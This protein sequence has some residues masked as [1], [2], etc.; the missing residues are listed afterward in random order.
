MVCRAAMMREDGKTIEQ[1]AAWVKDTKKI[2]RQH[3]FVDDLQFLSR[4][5]RISG[6]A[7][8]GGAMPRFLRTD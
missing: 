1:I 4:G 5:G 6:V 2:V 7:A 8:F 3:F